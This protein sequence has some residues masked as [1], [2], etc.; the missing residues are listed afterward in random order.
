M[1]GLNKII[2]K[3]ASYREKRRIVLLYHHIGEP[4]ADPWEMAV[5]LKHFRDHLDVLANDYQ[6]LPLSSIRQQNKLPSHRTPA[7]I[8]FDDAYLDNYTSA[9]PAL[10]EYQAPATFFIPT[11]VLT[12]E[13]GFWWE[14][15]EEILFGDHPLPDQ[16]SLSLSGKTYQWNTRPVALR[17]KTCFEL[18]AL[19]RELPPL[20]QHDVLSRLKSWAGVEA[21]SNNFFAKMTA[22]QIQEVYQSRLVEIGAHTVH[23]PALSYLPE[24]M[25]VQEISDSKERLESLLSSPVQAFAYPHGNYNAL[26]KSL[27]QR[28]GFSMAFTTEENSFTRHT[29]Q[30]EIPRIWIKDWDKSRFSQ[31]LNKWLK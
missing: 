2:K 28:S 3:I 20:I 18:S 19:I 11:Q 8:T 22:M 12:G 1:S 21:P 6:L 27:I 25:Q 31:E 14:A 13:P 9:F 15:V 5:S 26:T 10:R 16:L 17:Q 23:H 7:F 24:E 4:V 29:D 30:V